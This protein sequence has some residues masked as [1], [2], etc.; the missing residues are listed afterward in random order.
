MELVKKIYLTC[1]SD[2]DSGV[3]KGKHNFKPIYFNF[4]ANENLILAFIVK[5]V[6]F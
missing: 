3:T 5:K 1:T 4:V 6:N 2:P